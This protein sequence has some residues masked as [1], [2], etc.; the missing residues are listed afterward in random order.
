[1]SG[2]LN[3]AMQAVK[4][5]ISK[6][7]KTISLLFFIRDFLQPRQADSFAHRP[8]RPGRL[9]QPDTLQTRGCV[10]RCLRLRRN[11][12]DQEE[13]ELSLAQ[14]NSAEAVAYAACMM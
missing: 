4:R 8:P 14:R 10:N 1:M 3:K 9:P 13:R 11:Y 5:T 2:G 6:G 7:K 12:C